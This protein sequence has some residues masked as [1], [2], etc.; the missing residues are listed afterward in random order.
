MRAGIT[1]KGDTGRTGVGSARQRTTVVPTV[2]P[3]TGFAALGSCLAASGRRALG[4]PQTRSPATV[5]S[6]AL[7]SSVRHGVP[8]RELRGGG[9]VHAGLVRGTTLLAIS[10]PTGDSAVSHASLAKSISPELV[11]I[12][13]MLAS[14][15][16]TEALSMFD[17]FDPDGPTPSANGSA[18]ASAVHDTP[19]VEA[20]L[21]AAG[22]ISADQ[23][24]ELVREAVLTHRP[25]AEVAIER[26]L[27]TRRSLEA[28]LAGAGI[29][30]SVSELL[31]EPT[32]VTPVA[33]PAPA[34]PA[35]SPGSVSP[36]DSP[37]APIT[38]AVPPVA[39]AG[40]V[41]PGVPLLTFEAVPPLPEIAFVTSRPITAAAPAPTPTAAHAASAVVSAA[42]P[43]QP[44]P[45]LSLDDRVW[46]AVAQAADG[47][48]TGPPAPTIPTAPEHG[49][50]APSSHNAPAPPAFVVL[51]RLASGEQVAADASDNLETAA[52]LARSLAGRFTR[53]G[54]WPFIGGRFI[55]LEAVVSIDIERAL[56]L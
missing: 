23:L 46:A 54:E 44:L 21:F 33:P 26:G 29:N 35:Q 4:G 50:D 41:S 36:V 25:V 19:S 9:H 32:P 28:L 8:I 53:G 12:D 6:R 27:T 24:G 52:Q 31:G 20:L 10:S 40:D 16:V 13:P 22:A 30:D 17:A 42:S 34:D 3:P 49:L 37:A 11:L 43:P 14:H 1:Q 7:S 5:L 55:R 51:V 45:D 18:T 2:S 38:P 56:E 15:L 39:P 47:T 48:P